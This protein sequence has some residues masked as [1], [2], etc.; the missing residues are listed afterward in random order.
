MI[1]MV[2]KAIQPDDAANQ[3]EAD[4]NSPP[5]KKTRNVRNSAINIAVILRQFGLP[6]SALAPSA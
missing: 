1:G 5:T 2:V 4:I 3:E 6:G